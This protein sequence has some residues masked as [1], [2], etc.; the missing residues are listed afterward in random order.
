MLAQRN[1][2][3]FEDE[4]QSRQNVKRS[5]TQSQKRASVE[6]K[7]ADDEEEKLEK[8]DSQNSL[9]RER[10]SWLSDDDDQV[11]H[12][13]LASDSSYGNMSLSLD[14]LCPDVSFHTESQIKMLKPLKTEGVT[15]HHAQVGRS[16]GSSWVGA[17]PEEEGMSGV[18]TESTGGTDIMI[19]SGAIEVSVRRS[20]LATRCPHLQALL[21]MPLSK[22][23][24][25]LPSWVQP[26]ALH[27]TLKYIYSDD[28]AHLGKDVTGTLAILRCADILHLRGLISYCMKVLLAALGPESAVEILSTCYAHLVALTG[29]PVDI[30]EVSFGSEQWENLWKR[31]WDASTV[32]LAPPHTAALR[33]LQCV[34]D[35]RLLEA[36]LQMAQLYRATPDAVDEFAN[37][38]SRWC[39]KNRAS[40][41]AFAK[42]MGGEIPPE[43]GHYQ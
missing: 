26:A 37:A 34:T 42:A 17:E 11:D 9:R 41:T 30:S 1:S 32:S 14:F 39:L 13:K 28:T 22:S 20:V 7:L 36:V 6:F 40:P 12:L 4:E 8:H 27:S 23:T 25:H 16:L 3:A 21:D 31:S 29:K 19:I 10:K 5:S 2:T 33:Q 18:L 24:M 38:V 43:L 15:G 35:G